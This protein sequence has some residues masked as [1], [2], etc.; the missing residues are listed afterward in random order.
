MG[1]TPLH[2]AA[3][4][5]RVQTLNLLLEKGADPHIENLEGMVPFD[6]V[7]RLLENTPR[8]RLFMDNPVWKTTKEIYEVLD[9][10]T[11]DEEE[12]VEDEV[13][14]VGAGR[15][16]SGGKSSQG[17]I[18]G[19]TFTVR[20]RSQQQASSTDSGDTPDVQVKVRVKSKQK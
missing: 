17:D 16:S 11:E 19:A 18:G 15:E 12:G 5:R 3:G 20:K 13:E 10:V 8:K 9:R 14:E 4:Y 7:E 1:L 6:L 2:M